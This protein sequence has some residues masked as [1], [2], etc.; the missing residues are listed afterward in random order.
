MTGTHTFEAH[1]IVPC[2]VALY[3]HWVDECAYPVAD[4]D[5]LSTEVIVV[6]N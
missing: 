4:Y 5:W 2:W 3:Y 6:F 1:W